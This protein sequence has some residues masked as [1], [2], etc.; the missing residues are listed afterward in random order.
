MSYNLHQE[1]IVIDGL[2]Y[3]NWDRTIFQQ[4][5]QGGVSAVHVTIAYWENTMETLRNIGRW[6]RLFEGNGDLIM[7]VK[8]ADD[9]RIAKE[10]GK[11]GI[12]FGFQNCS[13]IADDS[14][15]VK[16]F[17][18]LNVRIMQ[19]TYNNQSLLASGCYEENDSGITRFGKVVIEEMNRIGMVIDMSHSGDRSTL[20]AIEHSTRPI[21]ISHA[22]PKF[23]EPALRNKSNT[24][25]K[26]IAESG[27]MLGFSAYPLHLRNGSNCTLTDFCDMVARTADLIG[28]DTIGIGTDLCVNHDYSVL[29]WMRNGRWTKQPDYGEGTATVKDWP[30]PLT[31]LRNSADFSNLTQGLLDKGFTQEETAK[32]MGQNWLNFFDSSF[33]PA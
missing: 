31:W 25:L 2:Q 21:T 6:N 15:L 28:V 12:I 17:H 14:N 4:L 5:R 30:A 10:Q 27:G 29:K 3:S 24:V 19:L 26:A 13:P 22:N 9:I 7:P 18:Q 32:I 16:V 20:E 8:V 23:F 33:I 1:S 11:V